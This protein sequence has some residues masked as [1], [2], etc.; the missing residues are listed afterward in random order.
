MG[1]IKEIVREILFRLPIAV[2]QNIKYD[3]DTYKV[4]NHHLKPGDICVDVG[5]HKGEILRWMKEFAPGARH[6]GFEP[7]PD[8][9]E[10]LK[11][12]TGTDYR[13]HNLALSKYQGKAT[14]TQV[15]NNPAYSGFRKR[16]YKTDQEETREIKVS[17]DTMDNII[18]EEEQ[19]SLIKIDVEGAELEV[20]E[21]AVNTIKRSK[22][23]IIFEHG[24]GASDHYKTTPADIYGLLHDQCGMQVSTLDRWLKG[25]PA[26]DLAELE[27]QYREKINYYFVAYPA[28]T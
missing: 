6:Y 2:T 17:V 26:F 18:P 14:F 24:V 5:C 10:A 11:H 16:T 8:L 15:V 28:R 13:L 12:T 19:I 23:L 20:L 22:P 27:R 1:K 25:K 7:L 3:Q 21:G 9:F 4:F